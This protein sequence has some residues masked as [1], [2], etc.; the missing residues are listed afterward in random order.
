MKAEILPIQELDIT[1]LRQ[2]S[3]KN[4]NLE[5]QIIDATVAK[6]YEAATT[7][8]M[9]DKPPELGQDADVQATFNDLLVYIR[10]VVQSEDEYQLSDAE[11]PRAIENYV[12]QSGKNWLQLFNQY[13]YS[14][15]S[16]APRFN[17]IAISDDQG[18]AN[19]NYTT[20]KQYYDKIFPRYQHVIELMEKYSY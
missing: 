6:W 17:A 19:E 11:I 18:K 13:I 12:T 7:S 16:L 1:A 14:V 15:V 5:E 2:A 20:T 10:S 9:G 4:S 3:L 8:L